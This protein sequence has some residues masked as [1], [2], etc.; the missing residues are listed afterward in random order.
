MLRPGWPW[1]QSIEDNPLKGAYVAW[2]GV[3]LRQCRRGSCPWTVPE[4]DQAHKQCGGHLTEH[5][6]TRTAVSDRSLRCDRSAEMYRGE[7]ACPLT[8]VALPRSSATLSYTLSI[9]MYNLASGNESGEMTVD[10]TSCMVGPGRLV[11]ELTPQ[12]DD[13]RPPLAQPASIVTHRLA[14]SLTSEL[15]T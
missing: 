8:L 10:S 12:S 9:L 2:P 4:W 15:A 11:V 14:Q 1:E 13:Q 7:R 5:S 3:E 6:L